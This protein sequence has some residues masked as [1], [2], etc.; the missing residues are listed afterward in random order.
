MNSRYLITVLFIMV[1]LA[2]CNTSRNEEEN[3]QKL[4]DRQT[5]IEQA[6]E[7]SVD[8]LE[9]I[10]DSLATQRRS[11][12]DQR[13]STDL[14]IRDLEKNQTMLTNQLNEVEA[15]GVTEE[16]SDLESRVSSYKDSI[17]ILKQKLFELNNELDSVERNITI[18][19]IQEKQTE[20]YL[21]S[22]ISEIDQQMVRRENQKQQILKRLNLLRK[23]LLVADKKMEAYEL[24]RQM[25][26]EELDELLR[27][28][29]SEQEKSPF[30]TR[31]ASLDS[32]LRE[33]QTQKE[34][35]ERE[36]S[37]AQT[38]VA[39]T[40]AFLNNMKAQIDKE[41]DRKTIIEEF[42]TAE[43]KRLESELQ[44]IQSTRE[45]LLKEQTSIANALATT[46]QQIAYL[47]RDLEL[48]RNREMS[49]L[50]ELQASIEHS[51]ASLAEEEIEFFQEGRTGSSRI[52]PSDSTP[53][54]LLSL[55]EMGNQLDS[56][57]ELIEEEKAELAR[58]RK[59]LADRR[60]ESA[61]RR[62]SFG[63]AVWITVLIL[64]VAGAA[65]L[66][67]FYLLGRRSRKS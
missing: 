47:D 20:A 32:A 29:A 46:E 7:Q 1:L 23:R 36:I 62:A 35:L 64:A 4:L 30:H 12:L 66:T 15:S 34:S 28:N 25:Y 9:E 19:Q 33:Q 21:E 37:Q 41:Y 31:I 59:A 45:S 26:V 56:L 18:Y 67:L 16:K 13:D 40:D 27:E 22:G 51:E 49:D 61:E 65:L 2:A 55:L 38:S 60:A 43:K 8:R 54:E 11:L 24:E 6:Q 50:L 14:H 48:I 10:R 63:R 42:I 57:N 5:Q 3:L 58:T 39:E 44:G 17:A 52:S 53:E